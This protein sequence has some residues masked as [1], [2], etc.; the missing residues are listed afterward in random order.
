MS[1]RHMVDMA[2]TPEEKEEAVESATLPAV[3]S[4]PDYPYG[5]CLRLSHEELEK[6]G[7]DADCEIGDM[8]HLFAM[9][10]V[11]SVSMSDSERGGH[12]CNVE[13]QITHLGLED[14]DT[15]EE[16][17]ESPGRVSRRTR[18]AEA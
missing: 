3:D 10:K 6:L 2:R 5:L 9:A 13:L 16:P 18:Y 15:E 8:I 17:D 14:E 4:V 7:L 1:F 11:T 12:Y